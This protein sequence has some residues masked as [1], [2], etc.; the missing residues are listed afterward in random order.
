MDIQSRYNSLLNEA[1]AMFFFFNASSDKLSL[2][3]KSFNVLYASTEHVST[4]EFE[5]VL[6]SIEAEI[7]DICIANKISQEK[8]EELTENNFS[9]KN[10]SI[11]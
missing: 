3:F 7:E 2:A 4:E 9:F 6:N 8:L 5:V 10:V 11:N 1:K